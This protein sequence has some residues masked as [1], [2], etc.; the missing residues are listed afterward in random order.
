MST[1]IDFTTRQPHA[2][3]PEAPT[4]CLIRVCFIGRPDVE[5]FVSVDQAFEAMR[6]A[7]EDEGC[8][9]FAFTMRVVQ[10]GVA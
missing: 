8:T 6:Q 10:G 9:N 2:R 3:K 1:I 5:S 4:T 7:V